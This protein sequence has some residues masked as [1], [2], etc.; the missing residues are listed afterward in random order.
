M[1]KTVYARDYGFLPSASAHEN[2][3][4]LQ[5]AL[6]CGGEI[7]VDVAGIYD[8]GGTVLI[9]SNTRLAF[10]E[11]TAVRRAALGEGQ[12]DEGF[13]MNRGAYTRKYDENIEISGLQLIT[14][15]I[16]N[17]HDSKIVGMNAHVGFFYIKHLKITDFECLDL[18]KHSYCI[19]ICTFED[20]YLEN[21]KIEGGKGDTESTCRNAKWQESGTV[22]PQPCQF[23]N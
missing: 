8:V 18:G 11:G 13:I 6:D 5:R 1:K 22:V 16:D 7:T 19:Q 23:Q 2:R 4:A 15:G 17:I 10:A 12:H 21:L 3:E 20:A 9:G 14:N